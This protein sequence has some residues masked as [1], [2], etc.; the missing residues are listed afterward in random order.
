MVEEKR[1]EKKKKKDRKKKKRDV[2]IHCSY[3]RREEDS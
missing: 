1:S 3:C 2:Y